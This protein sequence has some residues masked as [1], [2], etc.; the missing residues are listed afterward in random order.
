MPK[1]IVNKLTGEHLEDTP[2]N[3]I[4]TYRTEFNSDY[5]KYKEK[6]E[7]ITYGD[8]FDADLLT[9]IKEYGLLDKHEEHC[10]QVQER[11]KKEEEEE[12]KAML[13]TVQSME[14]SDCKALLIELYDA[15]GVTTQAG[16]LCWIDNSKEDSRW[17]DM[18]R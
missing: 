8:C 9:K 18:Y 2:T 6:Y 12:R 7:T 16:A 13:E 11:I 14:D 17:C 15:L 3:R 4:A 10:K 5:R 1:V